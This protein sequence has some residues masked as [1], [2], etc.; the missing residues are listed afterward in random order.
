MRMCACML[1]R[2]VQGVISKVA[3]LQ[4]RHML[5][6]VCFCICYGCPWRNSRLAVVQVVAGRNL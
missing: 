1:A 4:R 5:E 6:A 2:T 3:G